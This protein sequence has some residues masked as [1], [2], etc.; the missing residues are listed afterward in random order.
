MLKAGTKGPWEWEYQAH[1]DWKE[2]VVG[3]RW[4]QLRY[5]PFGVEYW[6]SIYL[7]CFSV[8]IGWQQYR[9]PSPEEFQVYMMRYQKEPYFD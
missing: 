9:K 5:A 8:Y 1:W 7:L 4:Q 6:A 3:G 2:W